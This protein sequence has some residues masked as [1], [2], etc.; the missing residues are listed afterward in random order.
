MERL[1]RK[2][3]RAELLAAMQKMLEAAGLPAQPTSVRVRRAARVGSDG[4][5]VLALE[6]MV[7]EV[8]AKDE[9]LLDGLLLRALKKQSLGENL[10]EWDVFEL[11]EDGTA[12]T[13]ASSTVHAKAVPQVL[14]CAQGQRLKLAV[15]NI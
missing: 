7:F 4:R 11:K 8:E 6:D 12:A 14:H 5:P 13:V 2:D 1:P 10:E 3:K 9:E 15:E